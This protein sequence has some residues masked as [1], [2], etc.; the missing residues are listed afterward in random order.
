MKKVLSCL[1]G[2]VLIFTVLSFAYADDNKMHFDDANMWAKDSIQ[3]AWENGIV[4]GV[5]E[6]TFMPNRTVTYE[7]FMVMLHRLAGEPAPESSELPFEMNKNAYSYDALCWATENDLFFEYTNISFSPKNAVNRDAAAEGLLRLSFYEYYLEYP[8]GPSI[9]I[10]APEIPDFYTDGAGIT[11][12]GLRW[13]V[14]HGIISG[15]TPT[16]LKPYDNLTRAELVTVTHRY[17]TPELRPTPA[18]T[19]G[20]PSQD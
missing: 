9:S 14:Y 3:W 1:L 10:V 17:K 15:K 8:D 16:E 7:E 4:N 18:P 11:G 19:P 20:P 12:Q 6:T 2:F 13:A 5:T